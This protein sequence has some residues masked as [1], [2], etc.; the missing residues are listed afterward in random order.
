METKKFYESKT[1]WANALFVIAGIASYFAGEV[2]LGNA[3]TG[4][5]ILNNVLR[6]VTKKQITIN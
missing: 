6:I 3:L 2:A 5:G 1:F 4:S